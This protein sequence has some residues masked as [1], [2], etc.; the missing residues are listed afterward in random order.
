MDPICVP[1][2]D[3]KEEQIFISKS[4][5][6]TSHF[7]SCCLDCLDLYKRYAGADLV[8]TKPEP[9]PEA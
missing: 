6:P 5:D 2:T 3:G 4:Y 8:L 9:D 7:E 1:K